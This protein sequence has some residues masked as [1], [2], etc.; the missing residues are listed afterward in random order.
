MPTTQ[1]YAALTLNN[2]AVNAD[3]KVRIASAGAIPPLVALLGPQSSEGVQEYAGLALSSL[4]SNNDDNRVMVA[5]VG[6]IP[7]LV[8][9]L[10]SQRSA[11]VQE[12]AAKALCNLAKNADNQV[13]IAAGGAIP[14]LVALLGPQCSAGVQMSATWALSNLVTNTPGNKAMIR[15]SGGVVALTQLSKSSAND[16]VKSEAKLALDKISAK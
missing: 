16:K 13:K 1:Q 10:G 6:A 12:Q 11:G 4:C 14:L 3:N 9:L 15:A 8:A 5:A 2:L 7:P